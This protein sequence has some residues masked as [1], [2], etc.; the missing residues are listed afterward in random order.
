MIVLNL[1]CDSDHGFEGWFAS[2]EAFESQR[3]G[4]RV[5]CPIC[6]SVGVARRPSAPYVQRGDKVGESA[7]EKSS[8]TAESRQPVAKVPVASMQ[9]AI[10][11]LVREIASSAENVGKAFPEEVRKIHYGEAEERSIRGEASL[12]EANAL[13][14]EGILVVPVPW[15]DDDTLH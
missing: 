4:G 3:A 7:A 2:A 10:L 9:A 13:L 8:T 14:E 15:P 12:E 6:G 11:K 1:C 5:A